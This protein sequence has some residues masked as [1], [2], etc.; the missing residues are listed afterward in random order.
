MRPRTYIT[1]E[2]P[3]LIPPH[4]GEGDLLFF[5]RH[6]PAKAGTHDQVTKPRLINRKNSTARSQMIF[7]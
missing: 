2:P 5:L 3:P 4:K 7:E 1:P 6:Q